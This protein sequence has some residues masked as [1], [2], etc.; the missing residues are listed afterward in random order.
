M[1]TLI[2]INYLLLEDFLARQLDGFTTSIYEIYSL[3]YTKLTKGSYVEKFKIIEN[4]NLLTLVIA[5][6]IIVIIYI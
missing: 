6:P 2:Y 3:Q 1:L 5:H 4:V